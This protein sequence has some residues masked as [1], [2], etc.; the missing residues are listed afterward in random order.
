MLPEM[1]D[2]EELLIRSVRQVVARAW[3]RRG[4]SVS[5]SAELVCI[6][7]SSSWR[8]GIVA[9]S[10]RSVGVGVGVVVGGGLVLDGRSARVVHTS[11]GGG[12]AAVVGTSAGSGSFEGW[13]EVVF[14]FGR[15]SSSGSVSVSASSVLEAVSGES[16]SVSSESVSVSAG[17]SLE[18]SG[19]ESVSVVSET[20]SVSAAETLEARAR[21][22][23]WRCRRTWTC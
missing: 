17:K 20:V 18:V 3:C 4:A 6:V 10:D 7:A 2:V 1:A 21:V 5:L 14:H 22:R 23:R 9:G 13:S 16:V 19:G 8:V 11:Y 12:C 15:V